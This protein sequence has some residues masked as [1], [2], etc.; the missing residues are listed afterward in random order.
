AYIVSM[1]LGWVVCCEAS[2]CLLVGNVCFRGGTS[3]CGFLHGLNTWKYLGGRVESIPCRMMFVFLSFFLTLTVLL[4]G[5][6]TPWKMSWVTRTEKE[7]LPPV[8]PRVAPIQIV[9][10]SSSSLGE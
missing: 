1:V 8:S 7:L 10:Q 4:Y 5:W 3:F 9:A 6:A 2:K